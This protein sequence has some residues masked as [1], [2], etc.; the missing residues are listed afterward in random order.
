MC[1]SQ[2]TCLAGCPE[3]EDVALC[4]SASA[5]GLATGTTLPLMPE[6][7]TVLQTESHLRQN[8]EVRE[9]SSAIQTHTFKPTCTQP[10]IA[11]GVDAGTSVYLRV[12]CTAGGCGSST[13]RHLAKRV[14]RATSKPSHGRKLWR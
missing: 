2:G 1:H 6:R 13:C 5:A 8:R 9:C 3:H 4:Y 7:G 11:V 10:T 14:G 12:V